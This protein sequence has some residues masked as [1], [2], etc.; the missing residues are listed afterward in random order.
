MEEPGKPRRRTRNTLFGILSVLALIAVI[1]WGVPWVRARL[2][3]AR[4]EERI[5]AMPAVAVPAMDNPAG[6][7]GARTDRRTDRRSQVRARSR[8]SAAR[9]SARARSGGHPEAASL[10]ALDK[11][12]LTPRA[13]ARAWRTR[14]GPAF[15][16]EDHFGLFGAYIPLRTFLTAV[17]ER[18]LTR[19]GACVLA[20]RRAR[21][22][23][24]ADLAECGADDLLDPFSGRPFELEATPSGGVVVLGEAREH[25]LDWVDVAWE[26]R[27]SPGR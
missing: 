3:R 5:A 22:H 20:Y 18:R 21:G 2:A 17:T 19:A 11:T 7:G 12:E 8:R 10:D 16:H 1:A 9:G 6:V 15:H 24:P 14:I 23:W 25:L 4:L 27:A 26:L 13:A